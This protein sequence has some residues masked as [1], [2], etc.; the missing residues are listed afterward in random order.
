MCSSDLHDLAIGNIIGSNLYNMLAVLSMPGIIDP[1]V[2][3]ELVLQR[4]F[5]IMLILTFVL[6]AMCYG[7]KNNGR[8]NRFEGALLLLAYGTYQALIYFQTTGV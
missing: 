2:F 7:T 1:G 3:S 5:P 6:W 8:V 4:D